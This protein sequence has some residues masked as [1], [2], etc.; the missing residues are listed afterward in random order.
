MYHTEIKQKAGNQPNGYAYYIAWYKH[1]LFRFFKCTK[2]H[3]EKNLNALVKI[4]WSI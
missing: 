4:I 3:A 1:I 2:I